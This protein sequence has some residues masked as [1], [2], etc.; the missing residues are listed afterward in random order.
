[1]NDYYDWVDECLLS[2]FLV[3]FS[4]LVVLI[5]S[6]WWVLQAGEVRP[7]FITVVS[8]VGGVFLTNLIQLYARTLFIARDF[9]EYEYFLN[10]SMWNY[11]NI[12]ELVSLMYLGAIV[13]SRIWE[14]EDKKANG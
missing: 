10:S 4:C 9:I 8:T 14:I 2:Y 6:T 12:P 7:V 5:C 1:M 3:C 11:R 13:V